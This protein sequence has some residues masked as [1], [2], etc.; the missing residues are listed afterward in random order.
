VPEFAFTPPP[1]SGFGVTISEP[2]LTP[3]EKIQAE[4]QLANLINFLTGLGPPLNE[5][6]SGVTHGAGDAVVVVRANPGG[7]FRKI[8]FDA[9]PLN[10]AGDLPPQ[11]V[12]IYAE[13]TL[14]DGTR[15]FQLVRVVDLQMLPMW[16]ADP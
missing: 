13:V 12:G 8:F 3:V 4:Q 15:T 11:S 14:A 9:N 7:V 10:P 2:L 1:R 6:G 5:R 16:L